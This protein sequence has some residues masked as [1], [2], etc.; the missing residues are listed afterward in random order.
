MAWLSEACFVWSLGQEASAKMESDDECLDL[1]GVG[2]MLASAFLFAGNTLLIRAASLSSSGAD[3]WMATLFRGLVG[4]LL[5][6]V[7]QTAGALNGGACFPIDSLSC[8]DSSS[9]VWELFV[10]TSR[11]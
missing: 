10:S 9:A 11:S 6:V 1:K 8:A 4:V 7:Y 3:G 2:W 5:L